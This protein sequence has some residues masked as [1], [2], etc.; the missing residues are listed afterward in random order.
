LYCF[1]SLVNVKL[2]KKGGP[3]FSNCDEVI[4]IISSSSGPCFSN[5]L[6]QYK[7]FD[8]VIDTFQQ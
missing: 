5:C 3:C 4:D 6:G 1:F 8:G 2:Y 7:F